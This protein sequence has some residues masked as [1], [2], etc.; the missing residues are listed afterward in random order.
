EEDAVEQTNQLDAS[1]HEEPP[2]PTV[3]NEATSELKK[4]LESGKPLEKLEQVAKMV[5]EVK[6]ENTG[7]EEPKKEEK[8]FDDMDSDE[9]DENVA[10]IINDDNTWKHGDQISAYAT[11]SIFQEACTS[12]NAIFVQSIVRPCGQMC[13]RTDLS[14]RMPSDCEWAKRKREK[15]EKAAAVAAAAAQQQP[16]TPTQPKKPDFNGVIPGGLADLSRMAAMN[17]QMHMFSGMDPM[18]VAMMQQMQQ[19]QLME[20]QQHAAAQQQHMMKL[21]MQRQLAAA[22]RIPMMPFMDQRMAAAAAASGLSFMPTQQPTDMQRFQM[23]MM[24]AQQMA[25]AM[26]NAM[27]PPQGLASPELQAL[28][29]QMMMANQMSM[30]QMAPPSLQA[31]NAMS[32]GLPPNLGLHPALIPSSQANG[33]MASSDMMRR[34]QQEGFPMRPQ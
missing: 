5:E 4:E 25:G 24:Q 28:M 11:K 21:E 8:L 15:K 1:V 31:P 14:Y 23:E 19:A 17:G 3:N 2:Q 34:L 18:T 9:N 16:P 32:A 29:M 13:A 6:P 27:G 26:G 30:P 10:N 12:K 33:L 7:A 22:G 20:A